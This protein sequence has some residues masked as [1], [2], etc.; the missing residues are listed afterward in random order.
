MM[1]SKHTKLNWNKDVHY[2][3]WRV[4]N[5]ALRCYHNG[6][7][8]PD[9]HDSG[10]SFS[11]LFMK[12]MVYRRKDIKRGQYYVQTLEADKWHH[13]PAEAS[14]QFLGRFTGDDQRTGWP[15]PQPRPGKVWAIVLFD[16]P[17]SRQYG[18]W[19]GSLWIPAP[20]YSIH[21]RHL[22]LE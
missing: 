8:T 9:T 6:D 1:F 14:H 12:P 17:D 4:G 13:F 7:D 10:T 3:E 16:G 18:Y 11:I 5:H 21:K 22:W 15:Q 2:R 20:V 19:V